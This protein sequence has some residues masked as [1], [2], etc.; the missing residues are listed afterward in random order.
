MNLAGWNQK[1]QSSP[2]RHWTRFVCQHKD[3]M[4]FVGVW[5][6]QMQQWWAQRA[7]Q[8]RGFAWCFVLLPTLSGFLLFL[9]SFEASLLMCLVSL[10]ASCRYSFPSTLNLS[11]LV[12]FPFPLSLSVHFVGVCVC[13]IQPACFCPSLSV[14]LT[15]VYLGLLHMLDVEYCP[16]GL[17]ALTGLLIWFWPLPASTPW[18]LCVFVYL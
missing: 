14:S 4:M 13:V 5:C 16:F 3:N 8:S 1:W 9:P 17:F 12:Y 18:S 6:L 2:G 10:H 15:S 7:E 11:F